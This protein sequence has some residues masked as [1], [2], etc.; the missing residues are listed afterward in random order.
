[1]T[2]KLYEKKWVPLAEAG[3]LP[4]ISLEV[5]QSC[6]VKKEIRTYGREDADRRCVACGKE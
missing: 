2:K 5:C 3:I 4:Q 1:M 6:G